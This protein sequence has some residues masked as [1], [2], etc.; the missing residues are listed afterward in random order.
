VTLCKA[1]SK[2]FTPGPWKKFRTALPRVYGAA[3]EKLGFGEHSGLNARSVAIDFDAAVIDRSE[4]RVDLPA[5]PVSQGQV[6][7][8]LELVLRVGVVSIG[9][10]FQR[11]T[12][13]H[14]PPPG[15]TATLLVP[16]YWG[17]WPESPAG[18][19]GKVTAALLL[20]EDRRRVPAVHVGLA[21]PGTLVGEEEERLVF[22]YWAADHPPG[23]GSDERSLRWG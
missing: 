18:V 17:S 6:G 23:I 10:G 3:A 14:S 9:S 2:L 16:Q 1:Q 15:G 21:V 5:Y 11:G 22:L 13:G 20:A 8:E 4:R 7:P 12:S 19:R